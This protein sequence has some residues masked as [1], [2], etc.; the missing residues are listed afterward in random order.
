MTAAPVHADNSAQAEYWNSAA[1][2]RWTDHQE[3]QDQVLRPVSDRLIAAANPKPGERVI[4]VGCGCG[5]TTIDFAARVGPAAKSSGSTFPSRCSRAPGSARRAPA[6]QVRACRRHRLRLRARGRRSRCLAVRRDV[7]RRPGEIVR[8]PARRPQA[9]RAARLR[10]L[11]RGQT[12][13]VLHRPA[14]RSGQ[15]RPSPARDGPRSAG[16]VRLAAEARVRRVLSDA[17]FADI[18]A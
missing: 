5:A 11:A 2:Q 8:Q 18:V 12:E 1:G 13:P 10:L 3:H 7:L 9:R 6:G 4:D 14:A 17:G 15:A 16:A